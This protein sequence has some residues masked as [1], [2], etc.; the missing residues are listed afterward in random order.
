M[1]FCAIL[2]QPLSRYLSSLVSYCYLAKT[3]SVFITQSTIILPLIS[4]TSNYTRYLGLGPASELTRP[5]PFPDSGAWICSEENLPNDEAILIGF[6]PL[7]LFAIEFYSVKTSCKAALQ[8]LL[9]SS[10]L[11][12]NTLVLIKSPVSLTFYKNYKLHTIRIRH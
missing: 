10:C 11:S 6:P 8:N 2:L 1:Q 12:Q 7:L 5:P 9:Q 3:F 4:Q